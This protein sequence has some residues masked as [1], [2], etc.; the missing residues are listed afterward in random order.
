MYTLC[1]SFYI[2][3]SIQ[4]IASSVQE[5][6]IKVVL[7]W[8]NDSD[9]YMTYVFCLYTDRVREVLYT[10]TKLSLVSRKPV[11]GVSNQGRLKKVDRNVQ[12]EPQA[13]VAANP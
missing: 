9:S 8:F 2:T 10:P 5:P 11:F 4:L 1:H 7:F 12:E 13:E 6:E 3:R